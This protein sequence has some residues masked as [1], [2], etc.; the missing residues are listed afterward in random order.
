MTHIGGVAMEPKGFLMDVREMYRVAERLMDAKEDAAVGVFAT[1]EDVYVSVLCYIEEPVPTFE[2]ENRSESRW[3]PALLMYQFCGSLDDP[4]ADRPAEHK[5]RWY[6][7]VRPSDGMDLDFMDDSYRFVSLDGELGGLQVLAE[8]AAPDPLVHDGWV[9]YRVD[10]N[11]YLIQSFEVVCKD[12]FEYLLM[13]DADFYY[14][15]GLFESLFYRRRLMALDYTPLNEWHSMVKTR[16]CLPMGMSWQSR[17]G[18]VGMTC[19]LAVEP[20][21]PAEFYET[22]A[23]LVYDVVRR[24]FLV[25]VDLAGFGHD[26]RLNRRFDAQVYHITREK[27]ESGRCLLRVSDATESKPAT[28]FTITAKRVAWVE[29]TDLMVMEIDPSA[30]LLRYLMEHDDGFRL[31]L[32]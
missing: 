8:L 7:A 14:T 19:A 18:A 1:D 23:V 32:S 2:D 16:M 10:P 30:D 22:R 11:H 15:S 9:V 17:V 29:S 24:R 25:Y 3:Y 28:A 20:Y 31:Y 21:R 5:E 27:V 6:L 4:D 26:H 12:H 13:W